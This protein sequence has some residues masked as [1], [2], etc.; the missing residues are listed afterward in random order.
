MICR[1]CG[2]E[3]DDDAVFCDKCGSFVL[4]ETENGT[5]PIEAAGKRRRGGSSFSLVLTIA[6]WIIGIAA[7]ITA[8][9][10]GYSRITRDK[11]QRMYG[12][13]EPPKAAATESA[14]LLTAQPAESAAAQA[15]PRGT[16]AEAR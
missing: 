15:D 10:Y 3:L 14:A 12:Q 11:N 16:D 8:I 9:V 6:A 4:R 7:G 13:P 5:E 1:R 2:N